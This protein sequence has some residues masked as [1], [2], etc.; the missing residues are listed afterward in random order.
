MD[1]KTL[2]A[3]KWGIGTGT[4]DFGAQVCR[5][6]GEVASRT[7]GN[8]LIAPRPNPNAKA[9]LF[10][11]PYAAAGLASFRAWSRLLDDFVEVV[12]V[13]P[14]VLNRIN[15]T[16]VDD[17][18]T[19]V[20]RLLPEWLTGWT[21]QLP[22]LAIAWAASPMFATLRALPK[23]CAHFIK[24]LFACGVRPPHLLKSAGESLRTTW[25]TT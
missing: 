8:W 18:D 9:R 5:P 12:A 25:F 24:H 3:G 21:D 7:I 17:L 20:E 15:E 2:A 22:F 19:F 16:A 6:A 11:F 23:G 14:P 1:E 10:C 4:E 13:E